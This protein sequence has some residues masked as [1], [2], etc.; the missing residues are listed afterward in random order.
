MGDIRAF[1]LSF[2]TALPRL[3]GLVCLVLHSCLALGMESVDCLLH[4]RPALSDAAVDLL[5]QNLETL[6]TKTDSLGLPLLRK[7]RRHCQL[8]SS[9]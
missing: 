3:R 5:R 1:R 2:L 4:E 9:V 8:V 7:R 6:V